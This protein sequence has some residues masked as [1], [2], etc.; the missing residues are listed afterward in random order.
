VA[1]SEGRGGLDGEGSGFGVE[2]GLGAEE[3]GEWVGAVAEL[4]AAEYGDVE[5]GESVGEDVEQCP[6]SVGVV[7]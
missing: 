5:A 4:A 1:R 3:G 2:M 6:A 7:L